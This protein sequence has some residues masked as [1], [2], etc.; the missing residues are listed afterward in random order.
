MYVPREI[1]IVKN[2]E[3]KYFITEIVKEINSYDTWSGPRICVLKDIVRIENKDDRRVIINDFHLL[4]TSGHAGIR[5]MLNNIKKFYFWTNMENDVKNFVTKC[6]HCQKQK[7]ALH[8]KQPMQITTTA[9]T[10]FEKLYLDIVGPL[11]KD[12]N[13]YC[14][15]LTLQCELT[16]FVEAYPLT[17]KDAVSVAR[18]FVENFILR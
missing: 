2:E 11:P 10:A 7:Y 15:I 17:S 16:K 14:Y 9:N 4:P 13:S 6:R 3:N 12:V 1:C 8:T 18:S 5:R